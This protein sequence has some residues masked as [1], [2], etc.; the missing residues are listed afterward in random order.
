MAKKKEPKTILFADIA[1]SSRIYET[2]GNKKAQK[3]I[4][5]YL[6]F[7]L[8][9]AKNHDGT[10]VKTIGDEIMC[11]FPTA[12]KAVMAAIE[13]QQSIECNPV[14]MKKM[15]TPNIY[16]GIHNGPVIEEDGDV[17]GDA[18]IIAARMVALAKQRQ[19]LTTK[20]TVNKLSSQLKKKMQF[21]DKT[22]IKGKSGEFDI[23]EYLWEEEDI[24][25]VQGNIATPFNLSRKLF[26]TFKKEKIIIDSENTNASLGRLKDND[27]SI[28]GESVSRF[29][30]VIEYR[31]GKFFLID[32]S[33]NGSYIS[34]GSGKA[35]FLLQEETQLKKQGMIGLG[36]KVQ[37]NSPEAIHFCISE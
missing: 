28:Q 24:T 2:F 18:V 8:E 15:V 33:K 22:N 20:Q 5:A 16:I 1:K 25:F 34:H 3:F 37:S 29:H 31:K 36:Y 4:S 11:T 30:A 13:M 27:I 26:L 9:K 23:F 17:F 35:I 21:V 12:D 6:N 14:R 19:I 32:K 10:L 7:L